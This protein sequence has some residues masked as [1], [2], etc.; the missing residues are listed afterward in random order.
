MI[1]PKNSECPFKDGQHA[2]WSC[3]KFK[4]MKLNEQKELAQKFR[5]CFNC[6]RPCHRSKD[7]KSKNCCL[8]NCGRKH[9]KPLL[10]EFSKKEATSASEATTAVATMITQGG[11]PVVRIKL[12]TGNHILSFLARCDTGSSISF[13]DKS[14]VS[15]L[16]LQGRK[17]SLSVAGIHRP[18]DVE[19]EIV[20]ISVSTHEKSR[21]LTRVQ[22]YVHEKLK[23]ADHSRSAGVERSL[24]TSE[25]LAK[26]E[27]QSKRGS[28]N[29]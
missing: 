8:P 1:L 5:M 21:K 3:Q 28:S 20:Q 9:N 15:T 25:E 10:S 26:S 17:A 2:T 18:Q 4:S 29:S 24:P 23:L 14:I 6:L 11:L 19:T 27:I 16:Q 13:V 12:V 22:F 7:C